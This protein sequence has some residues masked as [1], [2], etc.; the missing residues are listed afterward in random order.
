[1]AEEDVPV[2]NTTQITYRDDARL[3]IGAAPDETLAQLQEPASPSAQQPHFRREPSE[4]PRRPAFLSCKWPEGSDWCVDL[5]GELQALG[6][7]AMHDARHK[8]KLAEVE[9]Q[10]RESCC[11][12]MLVTP[13]FY[14]ALANK[15]HGN[16]AIKE[17][18]LA[19][20]YGKPLVAVVHASYCGQN[21]LPSLAS[22]RDLTS[23]AGGEPP[24]SR[25]ELGKVARAQRVLVFKGGD[26]FDAYQRE[27][28]RLVTAASTASE[29][30]EAGAD[31]DGPAGP[32]AYGRGLSRN[33]AEAEA[34]AEE[35]RLREVLRVAGLSKRFQSL[36]DGHIRSLDAL[37]TALRR[38]RLAAKPYNWHEG[39]IQRASQVLEAWPTLCT[40]PEWLRAAPEGLAPLLVPL[41]AQEEARE[42]DRD[43][44]PRPR[45]GALPPA[46]SLDLSAHGPVIVGPRGAV[47]VAA[48]IRDAGGAAA[49]AAARRRQQQQE[50]HQQP[51]SPP[52]SPPPPPPPLYGTSTTMLTLT[53]VDLADCELGTTG[54]V[55]VLAAVGACPSI[56]T[57]LLGGNGI[58]DAVA[59]EFAVIARH[60]AAIAAAAGDGGGGLSSRFSSALAAAAAPPPTTGLRTLGLDRNCLTDAGAAAMVAVLYD[61][62]IG[63]TSLD[64]SGNVGLGAATAEAVVR[65]LRAAGPQRLTHV[66]LAGTQLDE[67]A[68][69]ALLPVLLVPDGGAAA[70][71]A[72]G[73]GG[74]GGGSTAIEEL[75]LTGNTID[76]EALA[77]LA[78]AA[79]QPSYGGG[80]RV[81]NLTGANL[82]VPPPGRRATLMALPSAELGGGRGGGNNVGSLAAALLQSY[83]VEEL[84]LPWCGLGGAGLRLL[85]STLTGGGGMAQGPQ[86]L[87]RLAVLDLTGNRLGPEGVA[88][89]GALLPVN[90]PSLRHLV[91]D[92]CGFG[93]RELGLLAG[94]LDVAPWV[95]HSLQGALSR[96]LDDEVSAAVRGS[97]SWAAKLEDGGSA[98]ADRPRPWAALGEDDAAAAAAAAAA[99]TLEGLLRAWL[100]MEPA[101]AAAELK[102][103]ML[104]S[105]A[106]AAAAAAFPSPHSM[107]A[108]RA[109]A[110][111]AA[112]GPSKLVGLGCLLVHPVVQ[113]VLEALRHLWEAIR[114]EQAAAAA[115]VV[116]VAEPSPPAEGGDGGG[117]KTQVTLSSPEARAA[118][119]ALDATFVHLRSCAEV[120]GL[121]SLSLGR[122]ALA[123]EAG[124]PLGAAVGLSIGVRHLGLRGIVQPPPPA[125]AAGTG[126]AAAAAAAAAAQGGP[127]AAAAA[128]A[129]DARALLRL[130]YPAAAEGGGGGGGGGGAA[131]VAALQAPLPTTPSSTPHR[132]THTYSN[133]Q[134]GYSANGALSRRATVTEN[135][136]ELFT[137]DGALVGEHQANTMHDGIGHPQQRSAKQ[138]LQQQQQQQGGSATAASAATAA[139]AGQASFLPGLRSLD[140]TD[141]GVSSHN[142]AH[143][144]ELVRYLPYLEQL[145]LDFNSLSSAAGGAAAAA[146][147]A[148]VGFVGSGAAA[149][150]E[151]NGGG[152]SGNGGNG[153]GN[154]GGAAA[155]DATS[156]LFAELAA[157]PSLSYLS[158]NYACDAGAMFAVADYLLGLAASAAPASGTTTSMSG[159]PAAPQ[160]QVCAHL[161]V[162]SLVGCP[163]DGVV[164]R[165]LAR[166]LLHNT[167]LAVL[168][169]GGGDPPEG[170]GPI[171]SRALGE[172]LTAHRGLVELSLAGVGLTDNAARMLADAL[173]QLPLLCKLDLSYNSLTSYGLEALAG[174][175]LA[176][177][178]N[179]VGAAAENKLNMQVYGN[180][181]SEE[182]EA[183]ITALSVPASM[184]HA[185]ER[186]PNVRRYGA[187]PPSR[188]GDFGSG[189]G[190]SSGGAAMYYSRGGGG[191]GSSTPGGGG[192]AAP[193]SL[194]PSPMLVRAPVSRH[195]PAAPVHFKTPRCA[196]S[197][198]RA[199]TADPSRPLGS[200]KPTLLTA[201]PPPPPAR[202]GTDSVPGE[203]AYGNGYGFGNGYGYFN[204]GVGATSANGG[205]A[206]D[207][208]DL[209]ARMAYTSTSKLT[210]I[211]GGGRAPAMPYSAG[212][213]SPSGG[214][215]MYDI[216]GRR[217]GSPVG[218]GIPAQ[219]PMSSPAPALRAL[220]MGLSQMRG[221]VPG[222]PY[223]LSLVNAGNNPLLNGN[224]N[225]PTAGSNSSSGGGVADGSPSYV[226][227]SGGAAGALVPTVRQSWP[228]EPTS[229]SGA[230][231]GAEDGYYRGNGGSRRQESGRSGRSGSRGKVYGSKPKV[232]GASEQLMRPTMMHTPEWV[233][234]MQENY[235]KKA[236]SPP[237]PQTAQREG[238]PSPPP[239]PPSEHLARTLLCHDSAWQ[240]AMQEMQAAR[241]C[242]PEP[243]PKPVPGAPRAADMV[244]TVALIQRGASP[245]ARHGGGPASPA[246]ARPQSQPKPADP[247]PAPVVS[248]QQQQ[249]PDSPGAEQP[250]PGQQQQQPE[251]EQGAAAAEQQQQQPEGDKSQRGSATGEAGGQGEPPQ[252]AADPA[253]AAAEIA[254][255]AGGEGA[256]GAAAADG[257]QQ[258]QPAPAPLPAGGV[259][260]LL[261]GVSGRTNGSSGNLGSEESVEVLAVRN[262]GRKKAAI[263]V[264]RI[265]KVKDPSVAEG[266]EGDGVEGDDGEDEG[267]DTEGGEGNDAD[268]D[269]ASRSGRASG[270]EGEGS[271]DGGASQRQRSSDGE[272]PTSGYSEA[273]GRAEGGGVAAEA[274]GSEGGEEARRADGAADDDDG[275][276]RGG[277]LAAAGHLVGGAQPPSRKGSAGSGGDMRPQSRKSSRS[278]SRSRSGRSSGSSSSGGG[279]D[280]RELRIPEEGEGEGGEGRAAGAQEGEEEAGAGAELGANGGDAGAETG[281]D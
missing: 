14:H 61:Y 130:L 247:A 178:R 72:G 16:R 47:A 94:M 212:P 192:L 242:A 87:S 15:P 89:L 80:P 51:R 156:A 2:G 59:S 158:L 267:E 131:A 78:T 88:L 275:G 126:A 219:R 25:E 3:A 218:G 213:P 162:L 42:F 77:A 244:S 45:R 102:R 58:E 26:G 264:M 136:R 82:R 198:P 65:A 258:Q 151:G 70:A 119:R 83:N 55:E 147:A 57:L 28:V 133:S 121:E 235:F 245:P 140:L 163:L 203:D 37:G 217:A 172:A 50:Q 266:A 259:S 114:A 215:A 113:P 165:R 274:A 176:R 183:R 67:A 85:V 96:L 101:A 35:R 132:P 251:A 124:G 120:P 107:A 189:G 153:S 108:R 255:A 270:G 260:A 231:E 98:A 64:L 207:S 92:E 229:T 41:L 160:Q 18:K 11:V 200:V 154:G 171:G 73:G 177:N 134:F 256:E 52:H 209:N 7:P 22:A 100:A 5:A 110:A 21:P 211:Y 97:A 152:G 234:R 225:R 20:Q 123:Q 150:N 129:R 204:S 128:A 257:E 6:L 137:N 230:S 33:S 208:A 222:A 127:L 263:E 66:G 237:R 179:A 194:V 279:G 159:L 265:R 112:G 148:G 86:P 276:N 81:M 174:A 248:K 13:G 272:G 186:M 125:P 74:G 268:A 63:V 91:L 142:V 145:V 252:H 99:A 205:G 9:A 216:S 106:A 261:A 76:S 249:Q 19:L 56:T 190:S 233:D 191:Y 116:A 31:G 43:G 236:T 254:A 221:V 138:L 34:E 238:P 4:A 12:V 201:I 54:A 69:V 10:I 195:G 161:R 277:E 180:R 167:S 170:V 40:M 8:T 118:L 157:L 196:S 166:A 32:R 210:Q 262:T 188:G 184:T 38:G 271:R 155:P 95:V 185:S 115:G 241:E 68:L 111:L 164:A 193:P 232:Y 60:A 239:G 197:P 46:T 122:N 103:L 281:G 240:R 48:M 175:L 117:G 30:E 182:L 141:A 223:V 29:A 280:L 226:S 243:P 144:A 71:A 39:L 49:A 105:G 1:M 173:P 206:S 253:A 109:A 75:D 84:R 17:V 250:P 44:R 104:P 199:A 93:G 187:P 224:R 168:R 27:L 202:R 90:L 79:R 135:A 278:S 227:Y 181:V 228:A 169:L 220:P 139:T 246:A 53:H 36:L 269:G 149:A 146:A 23:D 143:L 214:V 62:N 273:E 24:W